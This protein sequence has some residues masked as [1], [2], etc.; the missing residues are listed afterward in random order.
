MALVGIK[1]DS[2]IKMNY[3]VAVPSCVRPA[4]LLRAVY[5]K[6]RST[7]IINL[8]DSLLIRCVVIDRLRVGVV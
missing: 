6:W 7:E 8:E 4:D 5:D 2:K 3:P 1:M